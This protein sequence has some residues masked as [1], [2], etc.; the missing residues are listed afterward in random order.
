MSGDAVNGGCQHICV[1]TPGAFHCE[2]RPG[3]Q[4]IDEGSVTCEGECIP[5]WSLST[6]WTCFHQRAVEDGR[7]ERSHPAA[8]CHSDAVQDLIVVH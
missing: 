5:A 8:L 2:C 1:N 7:P 3:Y 4:G 6:L